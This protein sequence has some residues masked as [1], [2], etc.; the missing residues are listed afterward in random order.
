[1]T[2]AFVL[3][4]TVLSSLVGG[5]AGWGGSAL[6]R[7]LLNGRQRLH[8]FRLLLAATLIPFGWAVQHVAR[9]SARSGNSPAGVEVVVLITITS[10]GVVQ[11]E[12]R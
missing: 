8:A 2:M 1:M 6:M 3:T 5:V 7:R 4:A 11:A 12:H 10:W 9:F